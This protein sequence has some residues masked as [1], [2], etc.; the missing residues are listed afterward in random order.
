FAGFGAGALMD[1]I[2]ASGSRA[3]FASDISFRKGKEVRL[4]EIVDA[5]L[6]D[7]AGPVEHVVVLRRSTGPTSMKPGRDLEWTDF[8]A[9]GAGGDGSHVAMESNE[10]AY[11]LATSGTTARPK[12]AVHVHGGYQV[13]I[14]TSGQWCFGLNRDDVW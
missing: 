8:L 12:L 4:K 3:V 6:K 5:A 1:R 14:A 13:G 11:I 10:P 7:D 9:L 2:R